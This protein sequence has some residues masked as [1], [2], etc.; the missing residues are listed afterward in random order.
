MKILILKLKKYG[1]YNDFK[2][3]DNFRVQHDIKYEVLWDQTKDSY[4][5]AFVGILV[6]YIKKNQVFKPD[7]FCPNIITSSIT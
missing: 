1:L 5:L 2:K 6:E 4:H 3:I 7:F